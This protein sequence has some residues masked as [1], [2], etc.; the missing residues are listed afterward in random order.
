[1]FFDKSKLSSDPTRTGLEGPPEEAGGG[2]YDL[3]EPLREDT[4]ELL[5]DDTGDPEGD[6][7]GEAEGEAEGDPEGEE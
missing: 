7:E 5:P 2:E 3:G 1:M 6:P 4:G